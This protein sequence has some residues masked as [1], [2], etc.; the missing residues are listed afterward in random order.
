MIV[1]AFIWP[2]LGAHSLLERE[3][4]RL[5]DE[6]ARR[7]EATIAKLHKQV[8]SDELED[9][10]VVLKDTLDGLI[11]EQG[12]INK[13]RTWPWRTETV[14]GLVLAFLRPIVIWI[15]QRVLQRLGL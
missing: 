3:K 4:Q 7:I 9:R 2:L 1:V 8:D 14:S 15:V 11:T 10:A 5:Q 12:V 13:L 6:V